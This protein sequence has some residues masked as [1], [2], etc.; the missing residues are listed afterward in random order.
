MARMI[1]LEGGSEVITPEDIP[2]PIVSGASVI[3]G[4][5]N[6]EAKGLEKS[7]EGVGDP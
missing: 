6:V 1:R 3:V 4:A 2:S 5:G 7:G